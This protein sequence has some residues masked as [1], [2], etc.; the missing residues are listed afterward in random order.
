MGKKNIPVHIVLL[1]NNIG[2][3]FQTPGQGSKVHIL[4]IKA[5]HPAS[6]FSQH[7]SVPTC[8]N[9]EHSNPGLNACFLPLPLPLPPSS[10]IFLLSLYRFLSLPSHDD[11]P[12]P[13]L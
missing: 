11:F 6:K 13:I 1:T 4:H 5:D 8:P 10:F 2:V 3:W 9:P 12:E 7:P